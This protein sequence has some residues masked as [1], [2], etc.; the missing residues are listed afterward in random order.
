MHGET[1]EEILMDAEMRMDGAVSS[2]DHDLAGFRSG[3]ASTGL[4]DRI[5]VDYYGTPTPISQCATVGT[6][7]ANMITIRPWDVSTLPKIEKAIRTSDAGL[8]PSSDGQIVRISVPPLS[9][10][11]RAELTKL[12]LRRTEEARVAIR[13]VRRDAV[14]A[15]DK[16]DHISED[17][18]HDAKD[19]LQKLTDKHVHTV[20]QLGERKTTEL[21]EV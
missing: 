16:L 4:V 19:D 14:H 10:E 13:N 5:L 12:V 17:T 1:S 21:R 9:E 7:E 6:P 8:N 20:D 3:R 2:L 11:R 18:L 15:L